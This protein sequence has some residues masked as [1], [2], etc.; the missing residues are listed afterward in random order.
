MQI[1]LVVPVDATTMPPKTASSL[2][3]DGKKADKS[4]K[5]Y[6]IGRD[7]P[8]RVIPQILFSFHH[9]CR[10]WEPLVNERHLIVSAIIA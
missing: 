2:V 9:A 5:D 6:L 8:Q 1:G 3:E 4:A 10:R 7:L